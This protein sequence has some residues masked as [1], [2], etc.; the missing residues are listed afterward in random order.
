MRAPPK[1]IVV[2]L[3]PCSVVVVL[4]KRFP[5]LLKLSFHAVLEPSGEEDR[6]F[7]SERTAGMSLVRPDTVVRCRLNIMMNRLKPGFVSEVFDFF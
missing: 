3:Y 5:I 6:T 1:F 7:Y 4:G 2:R